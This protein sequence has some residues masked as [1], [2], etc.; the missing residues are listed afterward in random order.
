MLGIGVQK[1]FSTFTKEKKKGATSGSGRQRAE[2][3]KEET[4]K[5]PFSQTEKKA[6]EE[7]MK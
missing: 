4:F 6:R 3:E 5:I 1:R 2:G 7:Q